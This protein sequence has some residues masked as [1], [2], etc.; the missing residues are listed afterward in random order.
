MTWLLRTAVKACGIKG[1]SAISGRKYIDGSIA[2][3]LTIAVFL[4]FG[5]MGGHGF[6]NIDD[7]VYVT[8]N[9][10]VQT[11]LS[12]Q[13]T[14]WAF[15]TLYANFWHPLTWLS[16]MLDTELYGAGP[17]G[18]LFSN[19]VLHLLNSLLLFAFLRGVTG[20]SWASGFVAA[21]FAFHPLHVESVAWIAERKDVLSTFF[22][23]LTL[24][25]YSWYVKRPSVY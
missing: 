23:M 17:G 5:Q 12:L 8:E 21:M 1:D 16:Y 14:A 7:A 25:G 11:G 10:N 20:K 4:V 6:V 22:W 24:L 9:P 13:N 18:Y 15:K 3:F 2:V 19:L